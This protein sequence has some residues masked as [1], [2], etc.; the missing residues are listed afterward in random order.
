MKKNQFKLNGY[1]F[2]EGQTF[3]T[4][5]DF[6]N[7]ISQ[8][9]GLEQPIDVFYDENVVSIKS[10]VPDYMLCLVWLEETSKG[11]MLHVNIGT[12]VEH[13]HRLANSLGL[14]LSNNATI[15]FG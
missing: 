5:E 8:V 3:K 14:R 1:K 7:K 15:I 11:Y 2:Y 9:E 10:V 13:A 6:Y 4:I 12:I